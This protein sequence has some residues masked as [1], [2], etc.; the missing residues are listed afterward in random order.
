MKLWTTI[1]AT[2][3]LAGAAFATDNTA[4]R[5]NM[6]GSGKWNINVGIGLPEGDHKDAGVDNIFFIGADW[7]FGEMKGY[8]NVSQFVG[9]LG[10]FGEG[11][12][13]LETTTFGIHYGVLFALNNM[14]GDSEWMAKIQAGYYNTKLEVGSIDEDEWGFGGLA[15]IQYKPKSGNFTI[16][17]GYY[18]F[19]EVD[20][21]DHRGFHI[22]VGF[23][24]K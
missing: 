19:P 8:N 9:I 21:V 3:M 14:Q 13:D 20:S 22:M 16:E 4:T 24:L 18:I 1:A 15:S 2:S 5:N 12:L 10:G 7:M 11:D 17:G 23:G 6:M